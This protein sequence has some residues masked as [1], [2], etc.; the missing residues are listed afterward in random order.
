MKTTVGWDFLVKW[1]NGSTSWVPLKDLKD[2][3]PIEAAEHAVSNKVV[4][5]PAFA[6]WVPFVLHKQNTMINDVKKKYW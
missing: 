3:N 6:W 4:E 1:N 5:K 2:S